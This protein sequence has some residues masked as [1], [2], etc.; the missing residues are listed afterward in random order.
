MGCVK[1]GYNKINTDIY[2]AAARTLP[3]KTGIGADIW[4]STVYKDLPCEAKDDL[5][6]IYIY[7]I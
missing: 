7:N 1:G 5:I 3:A 2:N 4:R 6:D